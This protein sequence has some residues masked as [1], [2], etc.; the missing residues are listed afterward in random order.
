ATV[1]STTAFIVKGANQYG[2]SSTDTVIVK[3][4]SEGNP[5][6]LVPNAFTP[7]GDGLNDCFGLSKWGNI[8]IQE[9]SVYNR[10]GELIFAAKSPSQ[11]WDGT[12]KGVQQPSGTFVYVI[13]ATTFCGTIDRKGLITLIR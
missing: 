1:N 2:C 11:C 8:Q 3:V 7:N 4:T 5:L 12:F 9:F 6:F 13:K 10:W